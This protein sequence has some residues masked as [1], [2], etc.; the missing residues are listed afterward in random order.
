MVQHLQT[1][2][3]IPFLTRRS[4]R[5]V[6]QTALRFVIFALLLGGIII[7][8]ARS[9]LTPAP[10]DPHLSAQPA[11]QLAKQDPRWLALPAM[12]RNFTIHQISRGE[13]L[14]DLLREHQ[15][16]ANEAH[17]AVAALGQEF[18]P[19]RL[20]PEQEIRI[21]WESPSDV[22][23]PAMQRFAGFDLVPE[24][25]RHIVVR[26]LAHQDYSA[27]SFQ[28]ELT[29]RHFFARTL[30]NSSVY[31]AARASGMAPSTV[32]Q[33]I[34]MFSYNIDFQ[35]DIRE[36]DQFE[37]LYTRLFDSENNL[38]EEGEILY[39]SLTNQGRK[40]AMWAI[41][42]ADGALAYYD[43]DGV[44]ARRLLMKTPVDGA[45]LSSRFG[46][47]RHP[48]LGYTRLHRGLDFAAPSGTPIYAAGNG[49]IVEIGRKGDFGNYIR[50]RHSNGY[51]TAYAHMLRFSQGLKRGGRVSQGQIIGRVGASGLATG[52][53]LHYEVILNG[54]HINPRTLDLPAATALDAAG[55]AR[56]NNIRTD[57]DARIRALSVG[58]EDRRAAKL[59]GVN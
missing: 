18:D 3:Q 24:P 12:N 15:V 28:R 33:L 58:S 53:H 55:R 11:P 4:R 26:R 6:R 32:I 47:R 23:A 56:L 21:F 45:R 49:Q 9:G 27:T 42:Q 22:N 29:Q 37:V 40:F 14:I 57:I 43:A 48:I 13:A 2:P 44:S 16:P 54:K 1:Q 31:E 46:K 10:S 51:E 52:P 38:A 25:T 30:I 59:G 41:P 19:R 20:M 17:S 34:R 7:Y 5:R 36:G 39:A 35:R 8:F 50:I